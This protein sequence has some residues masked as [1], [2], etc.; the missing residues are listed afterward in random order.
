LRRD[1]I[2][3]LIF[4]YFIFS[5]YKVYR[6]NSG[7]AVKWFK[8]SIPVGYYINE[9]GSDD[10][11]DMNALIQAVNDS[12]K[13]WEVEGSFIKTNYLGITSAI[14]EKEAG[15][16]REIKNVVGWIE[17]D[18]NDDHSAIGI[19][20]VIYYDDTGEI[21]EADMALNGVD[22]KWT[23][24]PPSP[25]PSNNL[26]DLKNV[27]TH[28][29]GHFF[30]MDHSNISSATMY[31][32]SPPC[33]TTKR[34]LAPDDINGIIYLYPENGIPFIGGIYPQRGYNSDNE[35]EM[36]I[37]GSGFAASVSVSLFMGSSII[38]AKS[39]Q[40]ISP[41]QVKAVFNLKGAEEGIYSVMLTNNP[42]D[43]PYT[44]ILEDSFEVVVGT[45]NS[46]YEGGCGC[47]SSSMLNPFIFLLPLYLIFRHVSRS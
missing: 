30:G 34:D 5:G 14:P 44:D 21:I 17:K 47:S 40:S 29:A 10:I 1:E 4:I 43:N 32:S 16:N 41:Q 13:A 7:L 12:F 19:T 27:V 25:C 28:E 6:T 31:K 15:T 18:W 9:N 46:A 23:L 37:Y 33:D 45:E 42:M 11:S 22:F 2:F 3:L 35:F 24:N 26:V 20:S 38:K 36:N 8:D 39:T